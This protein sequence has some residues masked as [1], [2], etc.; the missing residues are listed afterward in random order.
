MLVTI[1]PAMDAFTSM[2]SPARRA[3]SAMTSSVRFP[4]VALSR[5]PTESPVLAATDSV[6]WLSSPARGTMASTDRMNS[7]TL[8]SGLS[9]LRREDDGH[10]GQQPEDRVVT[11]FMQQLS[12][13]SY[14]P[15]RSASMA[16]DS[17]PPERFLALKPFCRRMR[18]A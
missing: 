9:L 7:R 1:A 8:A 5:P 6:A 11:D 10:E 18:V 14:P 17:V 16:R 2:Y 4:S 12:H 15:E 3:V 13:G